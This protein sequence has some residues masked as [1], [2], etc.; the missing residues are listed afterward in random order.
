MR[1]HF[2]R[3]LAPP[4][5]FQLGL[6]FSGY[7]TDA[8]APRSMAMLILINIFAPFVAVGVSTAAWVAA[9]FWMFAK[10]LGNP[11]ANENKDDERNEGRAA[12]LGVRALW[13]GWLIRGIR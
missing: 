3:S 6:I 2:T 4:L 8:A 11:N 10:I 9:A 13:E 5:H 12:V 1:S 7:E